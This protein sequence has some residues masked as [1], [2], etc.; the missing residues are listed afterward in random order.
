MERVEERQQLGVEEN[1]VGELEVA[2]EER[3]GV[4]VAGLG[5]DHDRDAVSRDCVL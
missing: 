2:V 4:L 5:F 3:A 1:F